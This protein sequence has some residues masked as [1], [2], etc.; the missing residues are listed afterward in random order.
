MAQAGA[1]VW[2]LRAE[3]AVMVGGTVPLKVAWAMV[4]AVAI[5][6]GA[7]AFII[8]AFIVNSRETVRVEAP[9]PGPSVLA[10]PRPTL[11]PAGKP[12]ANKAAA[13][14]AITDAFHRVYASDST[15]EGAGPYI[16]DPHDLQQA[17]DETNLKFPGARA[18]QSIELREIRFTSPTKAAVLYDYSTTGR[19]PDRIGHAVRIGHTWKVTRATVC[20]DFQE[21]AGVRCLP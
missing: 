8:G 3:G 6:V 21:L 4:V 13:Q 9:A 5:A 12:P 16:D 11:P 1:T 20:N 7:I 10:A 15:V 17:I 14:Q 18:S 2:P 19:F